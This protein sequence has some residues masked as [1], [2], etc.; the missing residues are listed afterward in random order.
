MHAVTMPLGRFLALFRLLSGVCLAAASSCADAAP[1][2]AV[3][4][5]RHRV[6]LKVSQGSLAPELESRLEAELLLSLAKHRDLEV[7]GLAVADTAVRRKHVCGEQDFGLCRDKVLGFE[8]MFSVDLVAGAL[9]GTW[10]L[11]SAFTPTG[12]ARVWQPT[13]PFSPK[14]GETLEE[15][16][17]RSAKLLGNAVGPTGV[18]AGTSFEPAAHAVGELGSLCATLND[19]RAIDLWTARGVVRAHLHRAGQDHLVDEALTQLATA[20]ANQADPCARLSALDAW[21]SMAV[22][23]GWLPQ[24]LASETWH[25]NVDVVLRGNGNRSAR[26]PRLLNAVGGALAVRG[27]TFQ[28]GGPSVEGEPCQGADCLDG[29]D[30]GNITDKLGLLVIEANE[31]PQG[32]KASARFYVRDGHGQVRPQA[33]VNFDLRDGESTAALDAA[34]WAALATSLEAPARTAGR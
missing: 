1:K 19:P 24:K 9:P 28:H 12:G 6:L 31:L 20:G 17:T 10:V 22:T 15:A 16:T 5:S 25:A 8:G 34:I 23:R 32:L 33:P 3:T 14:L 18:K 11:D 26:V 7:I 27:F 29:E 2:S 30:V 21:R 4:G 13:L